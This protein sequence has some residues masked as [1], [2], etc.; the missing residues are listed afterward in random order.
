MT[1]DEVDF[2]TYCISNLSAYLTQD[3]AK[4]Y[5]MLADAKVIS[6]YIVPCY[7]VLHT[8]GKQYLMEDL[9]SFMRQKGLAV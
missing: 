2:V 4:V 8:F 6:G 5:C 3:E 7:D 1:A 9:L